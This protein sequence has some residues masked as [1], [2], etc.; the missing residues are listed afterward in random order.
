MATTLSTSTPVESL[1]EQI[2]WPLKGEKGMA[3]WQG[4]AEGDKLPPTVSM[5]LTP[6]ALK[7]KIYNVLPSDK[8]QPHLVAEFALAGP[9]GQPTLAQW[10]DV[11]GTEPQGSDV[12]QVA[13]AVRL[14]RSF[15]VTMGQH[16]KVDSMGR[17]FKT[18]NPTATP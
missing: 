11:A 5:V 9:E 2:G 16:P 18:A 13:Q 17:L 4:S 12:E 1:L 15:V 14:I 7:V 3:T 6:S 8:P 10:K